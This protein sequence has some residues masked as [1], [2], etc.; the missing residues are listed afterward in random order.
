YESHRRLDEIPNPFRILTRRG[1][2]QP[3]SAPQPP[4]IGEAS[5]QLQ[6]IRRGNLF[7]RLML[8]ASKFDKPFKQKKTTFVG[9]AIALRKVRDCSSPQAPGTKAA[10]IPSGGLHPK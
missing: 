2:G 5:N 10:A 7:F 9:L 3:T 8:C 1:V 4:R 6:A